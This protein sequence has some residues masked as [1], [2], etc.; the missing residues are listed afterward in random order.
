VRALIEEAARL[1][2]KVH[3]AEMDGDLRGFYSHRH[4]VIVVRLGMSRAQLNETLAHELGHAFY[5]HECTTA[6]MA[7][8]ERQADRR[9][10]LLL[11]DPDAYAAAEAFNPHVNHIAAELELTPHV[12]EV[13]RST[14][15]PRILERTGGRVLA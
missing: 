12:I 13:W 2:V 6:Q 5:G 10:A 3:I 8:Q 4:R 14:W 7:E 9:G 1:G 15:L 11:V